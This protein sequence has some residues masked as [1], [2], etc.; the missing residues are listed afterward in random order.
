MNCKFVQY[1]NLNGKYCNI[2][3]G[4][5]LVRKSVPKKKKEKAN[6]KKTRR[7][8][9]GKNES[10]RLLYC[11]TYGTKTIYNNFTPK[12]HVIYYD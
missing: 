9:E 8:K 5:N 2:F 1:K 3:V 7:E 6:K 11:I 4:K 10:Y 12:Y